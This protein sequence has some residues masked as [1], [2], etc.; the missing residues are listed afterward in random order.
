MAKQK[1]Q[2]E[3]REQREKK[4]LKAHKLNAADRRVPITMLLS[5]RTLSYI[6]HRCKVTGMS[7]GRLVDRIF[8]YL[9]QKDLRVR[10]KPASLIPNASGPQYSLPDNP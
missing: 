10:V 1:Q 7:R 4:A 8:Q 2:R 9:V 6:D 5:P 3:Q